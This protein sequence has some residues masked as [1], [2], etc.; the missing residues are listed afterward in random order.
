MQPIFVGVMEHRFTRIEEL[1][2]LWLPNSREKSIALTKLEEAMR[3][4]HVAAKTA[5]SLDEVQTAESFR[6]FMLCLK[7]ESINTIAAVEEYEMILTQR[8][9]TD[10]KEGEE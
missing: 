7:S 10:K 6:P 8:A 1:L 5:R 9:A 4:L 2:D 3:W